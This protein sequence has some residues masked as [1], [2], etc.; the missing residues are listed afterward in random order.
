MDGKVG[1]GPPC[2]AE[3][4]LARLLWSHGP[5]LLP[6]I[7]GRAQIGSVLDVSVSKLKKH[8]SF[9]T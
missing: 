9:H 1:P 4:E 7:A 8:M 6:S 2:R 5:R 3:A